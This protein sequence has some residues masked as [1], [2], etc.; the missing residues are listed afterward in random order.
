MVEKPKPYVLYIAEIIYNSIVQI[1]LKNNINNNEDAINKFIE[2]DTCNQLR[3]GK[4]H[5]DFLNKLKLNNFIDEITGNQIPKETIKL[6]TIQKDIVI[7]Q[8]I[9]FPNYYDAKDNNLL[10]IST[11]AYKLIFRMC[12]SYELWC[13]ETKQKQLIQLNVL[14]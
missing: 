4:L 13:K 6:L 5:D 9:K 12:E 7:N 1:K 11:R 14:D 8:L 2:T 10:E 3:S